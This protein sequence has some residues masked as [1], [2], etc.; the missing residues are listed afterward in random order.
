LKVQV[1]KRANEVGYDF[2]E[3]AW[4]KSFADNMQKYYPSIELNTF[5]VQDCDTVLDFDADLF[6]RPISS[7]QIKIGFKPSKV[8]LDSDKS[9]KSLYW[10]NISK[11]SETNAD[12]LS[13]FLILVLGIVI[14]PSGTGCY[15]TD[16][17][18]LIS[19][20]RKSENAFLI[21]LED[22]HYQSEQN[23]L[24]IIVW[25]NSNKKFSQSFSNICNVIKRK[26]KS[27]DIL[28]IINITN[29]IVLKET[30]YALLV[31]K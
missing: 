20:M 24:S 5:E 28:S 4:V 22:I 6:I 18:D 7:T 19:A 2:N 21:N 16:C 30:S 17:E 29:H 26:F 23:V 11:V 27:R 1:I 25:L 9:L 10:L 3:L 31:I 12:A 14:L 13:S 15:N 8:Y